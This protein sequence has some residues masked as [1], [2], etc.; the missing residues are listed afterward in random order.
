MTEEIVAELIRQPQKEGGT[1]VWLI[2]LGVEQS[3]Q[4]NFFPLVRN[5]WTL[6]AGAKSRTGVEGSY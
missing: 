6:Y 3:W 1:L 4:G 5:L 2:P